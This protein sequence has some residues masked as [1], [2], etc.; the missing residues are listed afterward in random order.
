MVII[1][2]KI[3]LAIDESNHSLRAIE[4][5]M[6][7]QNSWNSEVVMFHSIKHP[8][9]VLLSSMAI[10]SGYGT[11]YVSEQELDYELKTAGD[12]LIHARKEL[13]TNNNLPVETR[14][15]TEE[16]PEDYIERIGEEEGFDLV[17]IGTKG[18]HSKLKQLLLGTVAHKVIKHS[19]CDVLIIR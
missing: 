19:P 10:P 7:F 9:K 17:V 13:F 5:V 14:L 8:S 1:Y 16:A 12:E 2:R 15:I 18:I 3:L 11:Y 6:E 4:K